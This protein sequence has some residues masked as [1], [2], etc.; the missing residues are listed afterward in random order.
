MSRG[1]HTQQD[2]FSSFAATSKRNLRN[3]DQENWLLL[4]WSTKVSVSGWRPV[5]TPVATVSGCVFS[6]F[7]GWSAWKPLITY[8][9]SRTPD[10]TQSMYP[11]SDKKTCPC[12]GSSKNEKT[13]KRKIAYDCAS[14]TMEREWSLQQRPLV[15]PLKRHSQGGAGCEKQKRNALT[16]ASRV[17]AKK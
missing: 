3:V 2:E 16:K 9:A 12:E 17:H 4:S 15:P 10:Y 11:V 5:G 7:F 14:C 6:F 13:R 8:G 1:S